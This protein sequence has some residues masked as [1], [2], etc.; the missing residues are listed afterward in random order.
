MKVLILG[1]QARLGPHVVRAIEAD[2][3]LRVTDIRPIETGHESMQV[4]IS[5]PDEVMRAAEGMDAIVNC[6]VLR[7]DRQLAFDVNTRGCYNMMRAAVAHGIRRVIN[8]GPHFTIAAGTYE[9]FD[10]EINPDVPPHPGTGLYAL[11]KGLG[12]ET[13]KVFTENFDL[14]VLCFLFYNFRDHDDPERGRNHPFAVTWRDAAEAIR[15]GLEIDLDRL[16]SR[17]EVFNIFANLPHQRFSN[18]KTGRILGFAPQ[19]GLEQMWHK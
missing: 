3:E 9:F 19:D 7:P 2:H 18:E 10:Y 14:Y 1:G 5:S 13:C 4:D 15:L 8:T 6:S 12:Q 11:S 17:C 16:P